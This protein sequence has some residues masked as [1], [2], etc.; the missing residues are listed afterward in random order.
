MKQLL[1][2]LG[3]G[4]LLL[5]IWVAVG[6]ATSHDFVHEG[7]NSPWFSPIDVWGRLL[8]EIGWSRWISSLSPVP[9]LILGFSMLLGPFVLALSVVAH[10]A[11]RL[12]RTVM[13]AQKLK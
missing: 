9:G 6:V 8:V 11:M 1:I 7:P 4:L 3:G 2:S 13:T 12:L 5:C 10:L